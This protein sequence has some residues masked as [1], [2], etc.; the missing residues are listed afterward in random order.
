LLNFRNYSEL[1]R[2]T[3]KLAPALADVD[4]IVGVPRSGMFPASVLA[5]YLHKPLAIGGYLHPFAGARIPMPENMD[6]GV[7]AVVDDS[8]FTGA[9]MKNT[10]HGNGIVKACVYMTPGAEEHVDHFAC[11]VDQPR[12]FE[13]NLFGSDISRESLFDIDGVLCPDPPMPEDSETA[14]LEYIAKAPMK[15]RPLYKV[16]GIV[17]NRLEKRREVTEAWL[18]ANGVEY[19]T[20]QMAPFSTPQA[21]RR[22]SSPSDLKSAWYSAHTRPGILVESHDR[23]AEVVS[24]NTG[25]PVVSVQSMRCFQ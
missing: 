21:R 6:R 10:Y 2:D 8:V 19:D 5:T 17:T 16:A 11:H 25:R 24:R 9:A 13:W 4:A 20:L 14:Y 1:I 23:I 12:L 7:W 22:M 15:Y 3:L 18:A